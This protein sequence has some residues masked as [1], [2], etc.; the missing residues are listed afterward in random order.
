[1]TIATGVKKK[2]AYKKETTWGTLAGATSAKYL[3]RVSG[4]FNLKKETFESGEIR[5]DYQVADMRHGIRSAE[6]SLSGELSP[7]TYADFFQAIV[8]RDFTAGVAATAQTLTIAAGSGTAYTVT[9]A[10]GSFLTDGFKIGTVVRLSGANLNAANIAK[11]LLVTGVTALALTVQVLNG[12]TLTAQ[13]TA[14]ASDV[15]TV[16]KTTYV[17]TSG[18]TDQSF[19]VEEFYTDISQS[20]VYTGMKVGSIGVSIPASGFTTTDISFMGKDMAQTGT[21]QYFTTPTAAGTDFTMASTNGLL[22]VDGTP[23]ALLT[24]VDFSI[25]RSME[26][27]QVVGSN[28][29][30]DMLS[31]RIRCTGN[32]SA[33]FT[34]GTFRDYFANE[35]TISLVVTVAS[36]NAAN[37]DFISFTFP[38]IKVGSADKNDGESGITTTHSFTALLND[39]TSAG[40]EGTTVQIQ[41]SQA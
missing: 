26:N 2:I 30:A 12:S 5:T 27:A 40:L 35:S 24:S 1:M 18:H 11:N 32:F 29:I 19:T 21:T 28:S 6:G 17:P 39:V 33:Y 14:A 13:A 3:R 22:V 37:A 10:A 34:N 38:K 20:E 9:R 7:R 16:G 23:V 36:S 8:A 15:T 4:V 25:E 41:E 31:G